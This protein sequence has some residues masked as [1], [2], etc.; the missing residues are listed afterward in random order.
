MTDK[1]IERDPNIYG[2]RKR[3]YDW[4]DTNRP[5]ARPNCNVY[6]MMEEI[7][8]TAAAYFR[9]TCRPCRQTC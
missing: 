3:F 4:L 7:V 5:W 1:L 8:D 9:G 6:E 2:A